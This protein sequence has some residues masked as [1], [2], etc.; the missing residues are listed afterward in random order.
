MVAKTEE[1]TKKKRSR[2]AKIDNDEMV[3][4]EVVKTNEFVPNKYHKDIFDYVKNGVG[5]MVVGAAAGSGK[6]RTLLEILK[7]IDSSKSILIC[8]FNKD[9]VTELKNKIGSVPNISIRTV[10]SLGYYMLIRAFGSLEI[11]NFKYRG[12]IF[13]NAKILVKKPIL[14]RSKKKL[15]EYVDN[16][17]KLT[18]FARNYLC[19]TASEIE[20]LADMHSIDLFANEIEAVLKVLEWG[21]NVDKTIDF[22]DMVWL[23][24]TLN[25]SNKTF[26]YD[27]VL[28]D[29]SQDFSNAQRELI[30][31]CKRMGTRFFFF[32]DKNQCLYAFSSASPEAFDYICKMP[33]TVQLPLSISYRC[34]KKVVELAKQIVPSIEYADNAD[35]GE[36][37][38]R[39]KL[40]GIHSGDM[41]LCRTNAPLM[42]VYGAL[43]ASGKP[44][45]IRGKDV[46]LNLIKMVERTDID[47]L[48]PK[49]EKDGVIPRLYKNLFDQIERLKETKG[50]N[51]AMALNTDMVRNELDNIRALEILSLTVMTAKELCDKI[52]MMFSD[53]FDETKAIALST[54]HK[55]KGL[56][57]DN[58]FI[59][60]TTVDESNMFDWEK[61][62]EANIK[63]VAYTRAKKTLNFLDG[64]CLKGDEK[65]LRINDIR[66]LINRIFLT[67]FGSSK[68]EVKKLLSDSKL[69]LKPSKIKPTVDR[70]AS[71]KVGFGKTENN[72]LDISNRRLRKIK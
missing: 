56:E 49:L 37:N 9:I 33:N 48:S 51:D 53:S 18:D 64:T 27:Y 17:T 40:D 3:K 12:Y 31:K 66:T 61:Q 70:N 10:H 16:V 8:A 28:L 25:M 36:V 65:G 29:E 46:G 44:C 35:D 38:Y 50:F 43:I 11:D 55:A 58:V 71:C 41:V 39:C 68:T 34:P 42:T 62:Q 47:I 60:P 52:K 69:S 6:T 24:I 22:I 19:S 23:P 45:I 32:G 15:F 20:H 59:V 67:N 21:R 1:V 13:K 63:Y 14:I 30:L 57:A 54:I 4:A 5:N 72:P 7:L 2:K 26:Q